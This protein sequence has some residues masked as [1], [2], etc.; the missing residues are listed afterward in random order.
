MQL[1][2]SDQEARALCATHNVSIS[3]ME[4]LPGGGVRLVCSSVNGAETI[5][6]KAKAKIMSVD[7]AREKHRPSTPLW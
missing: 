7:S 2:M 4:A 3:V 5:R 1:A 6:Q